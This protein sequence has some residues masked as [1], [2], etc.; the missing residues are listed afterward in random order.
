MQKVLRAE[1]EARRIA[2]PSGPSRELIELALAGLGWV[3]H[4]GGVGAAEL[5]A[6]P[7]GLPKSFRRAIPAS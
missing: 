5:L 2:D 1:A 6:N 7:G 3:E 4:R